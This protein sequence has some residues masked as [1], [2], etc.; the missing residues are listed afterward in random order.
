[1]SSL[2]TESVLGAPAAQGVA[3]A[4]GH[5]LVPHVNDRFELRYR[6]SNQSLGKCWQLGVI[7]YTRGLGR[8]GSIYAGEC[9]T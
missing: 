2:K 1:V 7:P 8:S 4:K 5:I 9:G 6:L 3:D